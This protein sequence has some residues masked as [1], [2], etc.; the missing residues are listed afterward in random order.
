[1]SGNILR[2]RIA[3][4]ILLGYVVPL[5]VLIVAGLLIPVLFWSYLGTT[6][7]EYEDSLHAADH[8]YAIRRAARD[9]ENSLR[10]Y[11]LYRDNNFREQF[12]DAQDTFRDNSR[13]LNNFLEDHPN[14]QL[15]ND[16]EA[17]LKSYR[18]WRIRQALPLIRVTEA[19]AGPNSF[20]RGDN[21]TQVSQSFAPVDAAMNTL[22]TRVEA[23]RANLREKAKAN[24]TVR[25]IIAIAVPLTA[26]LL[27]LLIARSN[28]LGITRPLEA[29]TAATEL[30]EQGEISRVLI[31]DSGE[32]ADDEIGDLQKAFRRMASTI[33]QREAVLRAQ[34]EAV[35]ALNRRV[36]AVL[37]STNDA[38][39]M[40]DRGGGFS[41][42]NARFAKLFGIEPD[43][44]LDHTFSQAGPLLLS[45]FQDKEAVRR[46]FHEVL[47]D[48]EAVCDETMDILEPM[49]RTLRFYSAPVRGGEDAPDLLG[50]IFVF[51]D[52]TRETAVDRMKTE[53]VSTVSHEL[54][55]PL[56][57]IKGYIDLMV[58]GQTGPVSEIQQEFLGLV[59]GSTRRLSALINDMLDVSRIESG[60]ITLRRESVDYLP[61]V[62]Q[63]VKMMLN[64]A[65]QKQ[66]TLFVDVTR[67][68][69]P[70]QDTD[71]L[72]VL[73]DSDRITQVLVNLIS[74]G[75]KYT[76]AG[77]TVTLSVEYEGDFVTTCVSDTGIGINRED[78]SK[79]FQKFF[80][81]DN[82][83]TREVGGTGLGL[84]I[85]KAVLEKLHGS[86][87]VESA[88]H[89]GSRFF[90]TLPTTNAK[91]QDESPT[92]RL[93]EAD[94]PIAAYTTPTAPRKLILSIDSD[95]SA[96]RRLSIPFKEG[97]FATSYA[98]T[99]SEAIRRARALRPDLITLSP[100][101]QGFNSLALLRNLQSDPITQPLPVTLLYLRTF[102][103]ENAVIDS[104]IAFLP[105]PLQADVLAKL[106]NPLIENNQTPFTTI[107]TIGDSTTT[108]VL[109]HNI[110]APLARIMHT[111]TLAEAEKFFQDPELSLIIVDAEATGED[112]D[113]LL[114]KISSLGEKNRV[115][116][117]ILTDALQN[118]KP[119]L[120]LLP[121]GSDPAPV[122]GLNA[123][124]KAFIDQGTRTLTSV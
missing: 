37:N 38:I 2:K 79:L 7:A 17:A 66:I 48:P 32:I 64:E 122:T 90:F 58:S 3:R 117:L 9:S 71:P 77:G 92:L 16:L 15:K 10:G 110:S 6:V 31:E 49:H 104:H 14:P 59:Q 60:R 43:V 34:N 120:P 88:P 105:K 1:M 96:L 30:L 72:P 121:F 116:V 47:H 111:D 75:I 74:N 103:P 106:V 118:G 51:R 84:A 25:M 93:T 63:T 86:I 99:S 35:G 19:A 68:S 8:V 80:R 78:Q 57:A 46:C 114:H 4:K 115:P 39:V 52:V 27:A 28:T 53:F 21:N 87:W 85:T 42:V 20:Y 29:L 55:T 24:N 69:N 23:V 98:A 112:S 12:Q 95:V 41:V 102:G 70:D 22:E 5:A 124:I 101:C 18:Q 65:E 73:G 61:L 67:S 107:L 56:T 13:D 11:V 83:T 54:R 123:Y 100:F 44:L 45:R 109:H 76:P 33:G 40:L 82:S 97:N 50:R 26:V 108:G 89:K 81:A 94:L 119:A 91:S 36:E 113:E 62:Q